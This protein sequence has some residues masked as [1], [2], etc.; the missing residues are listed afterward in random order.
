MST[1]KA[2]VIVGGVAV[3]A[4]VLLQLIGK[5]RNSAPAAAAAPGSS[6]LAFV[7]GLVNLG[8]K[9]FEAYNSK[10]TVY[11]APDP[12]AYR[13]LPAGVEGPVLS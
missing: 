3:G 12:A 2:I 1:G 11:R 6:D 10:D 13:P 8:G 4:Y 7:G 5:P 9:I